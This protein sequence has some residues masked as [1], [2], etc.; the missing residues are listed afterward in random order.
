MCVCVYMAYSLYQNSS[1]ELILSF[2][3][4]L[5]MFTV[6]T[7][8][9]TQCDFSDHAEYF[10]SKPPPFR[11]LQGPDQKLK[12]TTSDE[13][14]TSPG[15]GP[16]NGTQN[17]HTQSVRWMILQGKFSLKMYEI[18]FHGLL[19]EKRTYIYYLYYI[20]IW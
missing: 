18:Q 1:T 11:V 2:S 12:E 6:H 15:L 10:P 3:L 8:V 9:R 16:A 13:F 17:P 4:K 14:S 7:T 20:I 5:K 19:F